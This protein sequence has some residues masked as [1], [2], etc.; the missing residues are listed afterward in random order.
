MSR[1]YLGI[2]DGAKEPV[3]DIRV[4][5]FGDLVLNYSDREMIGQ[6][7]PFWLLSP[8]GSWHKHHPRRSAAQGCY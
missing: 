5:P 3:E 6:S 1:C 2:G 4:L 8:P 7:F